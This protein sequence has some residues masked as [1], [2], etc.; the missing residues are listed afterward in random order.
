M[1]NMSCLLAALLSRAG[2]GVGRFPPFPGCFLARQD[3]PSGA[4]A[5]ELSCSTEVR[6]A[7][8]GTAW[9]AISSPPRGR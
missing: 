2:Q 4:R 1:T 5:P 3:D 6:G 7:V 8:I 9:T